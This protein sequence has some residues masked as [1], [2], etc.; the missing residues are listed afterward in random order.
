MKRASVLLAIFVAMLISGSFV[1]AGDPTG[2]ETLKESPEV[3]VDFVWVLICGFLVMFM[4]AGFALLEAGFTRAKNVANVMMKNLMDFAVGSLAFFAVGFALMMGN[5]WH[6]LIGKSGWFLL[7]D[8]YDVST[9]EIWFFMLVFCATAATIVSG[10]IAERPKFSTYLIYSAV[11]SAII[12]PIYGHWLWGGGWLSSSDFMTKLGGGYGALDFAGSGVVHAL[13]GYVALAACMLLGPRI[14]KYDKHG[15]PRPI[16]G[17]NIA[18][19][20]I[21][22]LI[23]WFGWFG[24]NPGSTLS[25]HELRISIIAANTNLAAAAGAITAML[26]TWKKLGKPD[27]GMTCNGAIGGLVAITA[28]C[29]WVAPWAATIIGIVAGFIAVYGYWFLEKRGIDD[30]VGA[31]PVHGFNGTWGLIALG[32]FADGTYGNYTTELPH[33]TGLLYGNPGFFA[34]Q[35]ISAI[36]N[37]IWAFG[38]GYVLFYILKKTVGIRV[39]PEEERVGLDIVEHATIAYPNFVST[40]AVLLPTVKNGGG[41]E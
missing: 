4:Q 22:T 37:F 21:G 16:P 26:I 31:V 6:G 1:L 3:S 18:Y 2:A 35:V 27:V 23:L 28:P 10:A 20:V 13:G 11:V 41:E 8:A 5:D 32:L 34:C 19:A 39:S 15:N 33:I 29:A 38:T 14:G 12:Y 7:G 9:I 36:V 30:V 25:A 24:F 40:E 17:H